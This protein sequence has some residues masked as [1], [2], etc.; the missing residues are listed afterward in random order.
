[1]LPML[2]QHL[3]LHSEVLN[4]PPGFSS[5]LLSLLSLASTK[6]A[7][8]ATT[9]TSISNRQAEAQSTEPS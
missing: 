5:N 6:I 2:K 1:M 3:N 8:S 9:P 4:E 7:P